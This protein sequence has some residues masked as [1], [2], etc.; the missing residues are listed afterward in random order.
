M[1]M[2]A[3]KQGQIVFVHGDNVF[4]SVTLAVFPPVVHVLCRDENINFA[5]DRLGSRGFQIRDGFFGNLISRPGCITVGRKVSIVPIDDIG[6]GHADNGDN[7]APG[8][9]NLLDKE[10]VIHGVAVSV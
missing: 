5:V 3:D 1:P 8:S 4:G 6:V 9:A 10:T 2:G 7:R